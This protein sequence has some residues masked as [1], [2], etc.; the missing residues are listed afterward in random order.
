[1]PIKVI[2]PIACVDKI[3]ILKAHIRQRF[4]KTR[5]SVVSVYGKGVPAQSLSTQTIVYIANTIP[6]LIGDYDRVYVVTVENP[7]LMTLISS[8]VTRR[9]RKLR[10]KDKQKW[11]I[12]H[13]DPKSK[14]F[15]EYY[16]P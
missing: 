16:L 7:V 8:R 14:S 1:M 2:M 15:T 11:F 10:G 6:K 3:P 9:L 5:I 13:Y 12:L 4:K